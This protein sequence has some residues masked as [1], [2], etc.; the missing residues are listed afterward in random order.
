MSKKI[1]LSLLKKGAET[2]KARPWQENLG[3]VVGVTAKIC[4]G[5]GD[6]IPGGA[7]I[8]GACTLGAKL[9]LPEP[10]EENE[11]NTDIEGIKTALK[12]EFVEIGKQIDQV[13]GSVSKIKDHV[14]KN[15]EIS[16][17]MRFKAQLEVI[18]SAHK[19]LRRRGLKL[20]NYEKASKQLNSN[21]NNLETQAQAALTR[22][23]VKDHMVAIQEI[24][25]N[26]SEDEDNYE[27]IENVAKY[28]VI[29]NAKFLELAVLY[30]IYCE[31]DTEVIPDEVELAYSCFN[32]NYHGILEEYKEITGQSLFKE[33]VTEEGKHILI[34]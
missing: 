11:V 32:D 34:N 5:L 31:E 33:E 13:E 20:R 3:K 22:E 25:G 14:L 4:D 17:Q 29:V 23:R 8:G 19:M 28:Y 12:T 6:F 15:L 9:L 21:F 10:E 24:S 30:H 27:T 2:I 26:D 1:N 16:I 18:E 7:I